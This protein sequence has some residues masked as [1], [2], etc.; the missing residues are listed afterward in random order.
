MT[1]DL[2]MENEQQAGEYKV[3]NA[4]ALIAEHEQ[5]SVLSSGT[6]SIRRCLDHDR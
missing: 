1:S 4:E 2:D 3:N 6:P 5:Y